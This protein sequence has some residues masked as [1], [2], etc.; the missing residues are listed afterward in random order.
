MRLPPAQAKRYLKERIKY[1]FEDC[2][3]GDTG[4]GCGCFAQLLRA[5]AAG[6]RDAC[7]GA[8]ARLRTRSL[9]AELRSAPMLFSPRRLIRVKR[10]KEKDGAFF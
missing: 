1:R 10:A 9:V 8:I 2:K 6:E 7:H 4:L 3:G 5:I